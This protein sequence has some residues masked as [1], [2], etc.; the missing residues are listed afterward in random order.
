MDS[1][2][3]LKIRL[4]VVDDDSAQTRILA[5]VLCRQLPAHFHVEA[6]TDPTRARERV[7]NDW[8]DILVTDLLMPEVDGIDL[9]RFV[10][11]RNRCAQVLMLT[12]FSTP[13]T[14][15]KALEHGAVDYLLKPLDLEQMIKLVL[16]AEARLLRWRHAL[17]ETF[18]KQ[19]SMARSTTR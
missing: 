11:D 19:S 4:V 15:L 7:L 13:D 10:R 1:E 3:N 14:L 12:A 8:V 2:H 5:R 17:G 16:Q 18:R 9:L 6:F